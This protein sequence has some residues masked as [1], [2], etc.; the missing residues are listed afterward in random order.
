[1][2][3]LLLLL[4]ACIFSLGAM[5]QDGKMQDNK[6]HHK[7]KMEKKDHVMMKDGKMMMMKDGKKMAM[8]KDMTMADGTM[9]STKG[10]V[11]MKNGQTMMMKDGDKMDMNGMMTN[12]K[13]SK[14]AKSKMKK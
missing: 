10:K 1:M 4:V 13:D 12:K 3:K 7:E 11:T 6:M 2:K 14:M 5:A 9:V 8:D